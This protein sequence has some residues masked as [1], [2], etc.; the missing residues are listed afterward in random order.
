MNYSIRLQ[1]GEEMYLIDT[2]IFLEFLLDQEKSEECG[3]FLKKVEKGEL[4]GILTVYSL[5]SAAVIL[6]ELKSLEEYEK[7]LHAINNFEGLYLHSLTTEEEIKVCKDSKAQKLSFD[8]SYQYRTAKNLD[9]P[10]VSLDTDFDKTDIERK[11]PEE[12][13]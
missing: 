7:L 11:Q 6:E 1:S 12:I 2:N 9:I 8:D 5:H 3:K 13:L 10:I 4:T